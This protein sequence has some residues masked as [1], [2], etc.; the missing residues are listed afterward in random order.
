[1]ITYKSNQRI[2]GKDFQNVFI[3]VT[4]DGVEYEV[5]ASA[6]ATI[7]DQDIAEY[8]QSQDRWELSVAKTIYPD[9]P[10]IK[11]TEKQTEVEAIDTWVKDGA[12]IPAVLDAEEKEI[13]PEKVA[14]KI[15]WTNKHPGKTDSEKII[16]L[17][18][19]TAKLEG[20]QEK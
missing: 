6:P 10:K 18:V 20:V 5:N 8:I 13:E 19:R 4:L 11:P 1:M 9:M 2:D 12:K 17:E 3:V 14:E 7:S 16:E 15:A